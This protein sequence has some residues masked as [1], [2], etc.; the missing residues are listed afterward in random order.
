MRAVGAG[1]V[2][3]IH[4]WGHLND[5]VVPAG[6]VSCMNAIQGPKLGR[7]AF[8]VDDDEIRAASVV[9]VDL[10]W[11]IS[12]PGFERV[13][14]H[15]RAIAPATPIVVGGIAAAHLAPQLVEELP[16]DYA[17]RGDAEASFARL[18]EALRARERP[19]PLPNVFARGAPAPPRQRMSDQEFGA[20]DSITIDWFP[21]FA[22]SSDLD[23]VAFPPGRTVIAARGCPLRCPTCYGSHADT[24]GPGYLWREPGR[25]AALVQAAAAED[26][27]N[28]RLI[29]GKPSPRRLSELI[30]ALAEAGPQRL[31]GAIG[32]YVCRAPSDEDLDRLE[33][34]FD[35]PVALSTVPPE[36][37]VPAL[38]PARLAEERAAWRRV[39]ERAARSTKLR[40]DV[41][42][43][44]GSDTKPIREGLGG[45]DDARVTVSS[46]AVWNMSRPGDGETTT[47]AAVRAAV[48]DTWT[49]YAARLLSPALARLLAPFRFLDEVDDGLDALAPPDEPALVA[50]HDQM[51]RSWRAHRLPSLPGLAFDAVPVAL[52]A[53]PRSRAAEGTRHAGDL[54]VVP[55][56]AVRVVSAPH[57]LAARLDHRG[58]ALI[59]DL[60]AIPAE[61]SAIVLVPRG[62]SETTAAWLDALGAAGLVAL[63]A[64]LTER[65]PHRLRVDL[66]VQ[67]ARAFLL[68]AGGRPLRR[69]VAD[70]GYLRDP[71]AVK[72]TAREPARRE[73]D[74]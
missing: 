42:A 67:D 9:C 62:A 44:A 11:A 32:L 33:R 4:P 51:M 1:L 26:A 10:H 53:A 43:T 25:T 45:G 50:F 69:G 38:S 21:T 34:A 64:E 28:V 31:G 61:A 14:A 39:A 18:I 16:V 71:R 37:H 57:A 36:E 17:F 24:Y 27:R 20:T 73:A 7:Y 22:R 30:A 48:A 12:L 58:V 46:G 40:L 60:P 59:A 55:S 3:Y 47:L 49:F 54:A 68:D 35:S 56:S 41:W 15:V 2:L 70:L 63:R 19:P 66:R 72:P 13:V 6:A 52:G 23:A 65:G 8:E 29:V 5:L 74:G